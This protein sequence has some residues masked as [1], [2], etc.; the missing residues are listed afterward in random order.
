MRGGEKFRRR[1]GRQAGIAL[2]IALFALV[3]LALMGAVVLSITTNGSSFGRHAAALQRAA[4]A[5]Q[6]G[7]DE[8][9]GL[10]RGQMVNGTMQPSPVA[11]ALC[12][13]LNPPPGTPPTCSTTTVIYVVNPS[14][15][16]PF[17]KPWLAS[18]KYADPT[19]TTEPNPFGGTVASAFVLPTGNVIT[20]SLTN[21]PGFKWARINVET[22]NSIDQVVDPSNPGLAIQPMLYDD[23]PTSAG[24]VP[25]RYPEGSSLGNGSTDPQAIF[26]ITALG[27]NNGYE[28]LVTEDVTRFPFGLVPP[29]PV[30]QIGPSPV[31]AS[32]HSQNFTVSGVD[33][34][35]QYPILPA[36]GGTSGGAVAAINSG[37]FRDDCAH[38]GASDP[39]C[40]GT[41]PSTI[42][43]V[44][45]PQTSGN[46]LPL[47]PAWDTVGTRTPATGLLGLVSQLEA[48][49]D[50]VCAGGG[51]V[52]PGTAAPAACPA[53]A[54]NGT[55]F[56][57]ADNPGITVIEGNYTL[58]Q[59]GGGTLLV[60]GNVTVPNNINWNGLLLVVGTGVLTGSGGGT[61][62][63]NG[64][65]FLANVC[66]NLGQVDPTGAYTD[67]SNCSQIGN[68]DFEP[69]AG[70]G[71][72]NKASTGCSI[73]F[74]SATISAAD[75]NRAY[76]VLSYREQTLNQ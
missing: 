50:V 15:D 68:S 9:R 2:M 71:N 47:S 31:Y 73:C 32:G 49:A 42:V 20:S 76:A 41:P 33:L 53:N 65:L 30:T 46:P 37:A 11:T 75:K 48:S 55:G 45:G 14:A 22:E 61:P 44:A 59:N 13:V 35:G 23:V 34:A 54:G 51:T 52:A 1:R 64:A 72:G 36:M 57:D 19:F 8:A 56:L 27:V 58:P 28:K 70:G 5:A 29:A 10:L 38:Y 16:Y 60:T 67:L 12:S 63:Y 18:D 24:V 17:P 21:I 39:S 66:G 6:A 26:Q 3:V 69:G 40:T 4:M 25:G 7:A 43:D 62:S 74:D